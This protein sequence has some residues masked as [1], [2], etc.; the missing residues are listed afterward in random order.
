MRQI[1][2]E[3]VLVMLVCG[4]TAF[5]SAKN[6]PAAS[7]FAPARDLA[8]QVDEYVKQLKK[9]TADKE[10]Y[11]NN[12]EKIVRDASILA[13]IALALGVHDEENEYKNVASKLVE[14]CQK[15]V[16][17]KDYDSAKAGVEAIQKAMTAK[18]ENP[19]AMKWARVARLK[20]LM[21]SIS[22]VN[23]KLKRFTK[24]KRLQLKAKKTTGY[25]SVIAAVAQ[26]SRDSVKETIAPNLDKEWRMH[27]D[28]MRNAAAKTNKAILTGEIH[29]FKPAMAEL[30]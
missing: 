11:E 10:D 1:V 4:G 14:A 15:T 13:V 6:P 9:T 19:P 20:D 12:K 24:G 30:Q 17:S 8:S 3:L 16:D 25:T 2:S 7:T 26:A 29:K 28:Q 22:L 23:T 27:C 18:V 5:A 21:E